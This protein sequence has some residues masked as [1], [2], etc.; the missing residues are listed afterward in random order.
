MEPL[1]KL[2]QQI[3]KQLELCDRADT[4]TICAMKQDEPGYTEVEN[5]II[6]KVMYG[7]N[8]SIAD[9]IVEIENEYNP[10]HS[11]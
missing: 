5:L 10:N 8:T 7:P 9:A 6:Q 4:P 2:K 11:E 1:D 3:K